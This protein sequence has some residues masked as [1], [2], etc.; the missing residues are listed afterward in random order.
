M[1]C[2]CTLAWIIGH[3]CFYHSFIILILLTWTGASYA[4]VLL[5]RFLVLVYLTNPITSNYNWVFVSSAFNSYLTIWHSMRTVNLDHWTQVYR[6]TLN[7]TTFIAKVILHPRQDLL[8]LWV[9]AHKFTFYIY[10]ISFLFIDDGWIQY[11]QLFVL[12]ESLQL[13]G[14]YFNHLLSEISSTSKCVQYLE[15]LLVKQVIAKKLLFAT[16]ICISYSK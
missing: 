8:N 13:L 5:Y 12:T 15:E 9:W 7:S 4:E 2:Y 3:S 10:I 14:M 16:H 6:L 1:C 11:N